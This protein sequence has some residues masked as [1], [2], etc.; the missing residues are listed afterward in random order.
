MVT[1]RELMKS[2]SGH[3]CSIQPDA[4]VFQALE[5]MAKENVGAV[6]VIEGKKL[7]GV[8]TERDYARKVILKDRASKDTKVRVIMSTELFIVK[9]DQRIESALE[10]MSTKSV[11]HLPIV[12]GEMVLGV[13]SILEVVRAI[14]QQ[15]KETI[16]FYEEM[17]GER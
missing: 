17:D 6:L 5:L 14:I 9:P 7:V 10:L 2:H 11:R 12:D 8:L 16:R 13:I 1:I 4:T 3:V 15:Q